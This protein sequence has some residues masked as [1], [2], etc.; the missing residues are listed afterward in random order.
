[1]QDP[2]S[3]QHLHYLFHFKAKCLFLSSTFLITQLDMY[4]FSINTSFRDASGKDESES[5]GWPSC[6]ERQ[7]QENSRR[8]PKRREQP[9]KGEIHDC[10]QKAGKIKESL[11]LSNSHNLFFSTI[12]QFSSSSRMSEKKSMPRMR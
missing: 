10:P 7:I 5:K 12:R 1:M 11:R 8:N 4:I 3:F 9:K 6:Q 2:N